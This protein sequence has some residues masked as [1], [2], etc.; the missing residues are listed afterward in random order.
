MCD[1]PTKI[2]P[3]KAVKISALNTIPYNKL[4]NIITGIEAIRPQK[5][6]LG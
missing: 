2:P 3:I 4:N 6:L 5:T 1:G